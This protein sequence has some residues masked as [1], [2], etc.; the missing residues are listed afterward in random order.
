[1]LADDYFKQPPPKSTGVEYFNL[2][3]LNK[4]LNGTETSQ[5]IIRTLIEFTALTISQNLKNDKVY[6]C[7]G[8]VFNAFLMERLEFLN[9]TCEI[10]TTQDLN[11]HPNFVEAV[12]FAYFAK[13][14][15]EGSTS[16]LKSVTGATKAVVLGS[17]NFN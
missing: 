13:L 6:F 3:W 14:N 2:N 12:A 17:V 9:P 7:G 1:M 16:N 11:L 10:L 8:G 5:D 15:I 4:F